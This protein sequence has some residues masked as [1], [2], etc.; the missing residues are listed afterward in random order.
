MTLRNNCDVF[1]FFF[2]M[3]FCFNKNKIIVDKQE[4]NKHFH[5]KCH[6]HYSINMWHAAFGLKHFFYLRVKKGSSKAC[7]T[8]NLVL[9]YLCS[10]TAE[11]W[12]VPPSLL[13]PLSGQTTVCKKL[14]PSLSC[15][16]PPSNPFISLYD[17]R[18]KRNL[19]LSITIVFFS[20]S[21]SYSCWLQ[22][23]LYPL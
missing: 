1:K 10:Q 7:R 23:N 2:K 11:P 6:Q 14:F 8:T 21:F 18:E 16:I 9:H 12:Q 22:K 15:S 20:L 19:S 3:S 17:R 4:A 13:N 5:S